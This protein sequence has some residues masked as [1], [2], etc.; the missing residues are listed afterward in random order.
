MPD[1]EPSLA[2]A[3]RPLEGRPDGT[4]APADPVR[5]DVVGGRVESIRPWTGRE[6]AEVGG[7]DAVLAPGLSDCH[8]H[9][10]AAA[11]ART[12]LD[13]RDDPPARLVDLFERLR[14]HAAGRPAREWVRVRGYDESR[15]EERRHPTDRELESVLPGRPV[16]L[17]HATLH[18]SVLSRA[19]L[20]RVAGGLGLGDAERDS[21]AGFLVGREAELTALS[22]SGRADPSDGLAHV[23]AE[24]ASSGV[25]CVDDITASNDAGRVGLLAEA[26]ERGWLP[27]RLRAWLRDADELDSARRAARDRV[28]LAGV[29]LLPRSEEEARAPGFGQAIA[30]A[31]RAGLPVAIHAVE[32]DVI[33]AALDALESAPPRA[34]AAA[35]PDR[36]EHC[37]LCPPLLVE[38]L[39]ASRVAVVTQPAFLVARGAKYSREVEPPLWPWLYPVGSLIHAGVLV[40]AG[41]DTPVIPSDPRMCFVGATT[42]R[43]T[44]GVVFCEGEA[45]PEEAA[46]ELRTRSAARVRGD[47]DAERPW[48]RSGA[49]ADFALLEDAPRGEILSRWKVRET[50]LA[51]QIF[52][53]DAS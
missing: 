26:A 51:G 48:L 21:S 22:A 24:L 5:V 28:E 8:A 23:G 52:G 12:A 11:A 18:A 10:L 41:S 39:A 38:R 25:T 19:A 50:V 33:G 4:L 35:A 37:S 47:A 46:L 44:E 29:K 42:R 7:P 45:I 13:L 14:A 9:L 43:S 3:G 1:V 20:E 2:L 32:P 34:G 30:R 49:R 36:L 40:A 6:R 15:L 27:Q 16:R 31:R 17:R 53:A